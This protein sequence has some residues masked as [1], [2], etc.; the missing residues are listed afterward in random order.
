MMKRNRFRKLGCLK[1]RQALL[2][3]YLDDPAD[4]VGVDVVVDG[5]LGELVPLVGRPAVDG[6][7]ELAVLILGL[8]QV[9][10]H[11]LQET[12]TGGLFRFL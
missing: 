1:S 5:P 10:H 8:A 2:R 3:S 12:L 4:V 7:P 9:G 6:K 11:L